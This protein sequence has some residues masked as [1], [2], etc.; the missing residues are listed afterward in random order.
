L[1]D[2]ESRNKSDEHLHG[3]VH[4]AQLDDPDLNPELLCDIALPR[5]LGGAFF[6]NIGLVRC[7][8]S[9]ARRRGGTRKPQRPGN[10]GATE[11]SAAA[12]LVRGGKVRK[13]QDFPSKT[14]FSFGK[15]PPL[16]SPPPPPRATWRG[17]VEPVWAV[18][19][20]V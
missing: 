15:P 13:T 12:S 9:Q 5:L 14:F 2:S 16:L 17:W 8:C 7:I 20:L 19:G 1:G 10:T 6:I 18:F 4:L 3:R 11:R